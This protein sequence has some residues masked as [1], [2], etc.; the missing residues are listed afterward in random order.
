MILFTFWLAFLAASNIL[1][2]LFK[3]NIGTVRELIQLR[4]SSQSL[5]RRPVKRANFWRQDRQYKRI[6]LQLAV[7]D[8]GEDLLDPL[9]EGLPWWD[10]LSPLR[11]LTFL[12]LVTSFVLRFFSFGKRIQL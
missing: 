10:L 4:V 3:Q 11:A 12:L 9:R 2:A 8:R 6:L 7:H 1:L 5:L